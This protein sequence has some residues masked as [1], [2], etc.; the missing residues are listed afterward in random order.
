VVHRNRHGP[1]PWLIFGGWI[2][3]IGAFVGCASEIRTSHDQ[4]TTVDISRYAIYA[5]ISKDSLIPPRRGEGD[6]SY[7]SPIDDQ[8]IRRAVDAQM[9]AKGYRLATGDQEAELIVSYG[10]GREDKVDVYES[11]PYGGIGYPGPYGYGYGGWYGGSTTRVYRYTEGTLT[12]ELFDRKTQQA[13]WIGWGSKR[14]TDSDERDQVIQTAVAKILEPLPA[15]GD[16]T[17]APSAK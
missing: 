6:V 4:D 7:V 3:G 2:V 15:H 12:I 14:I 11:G 10:I 8:R 5:W 13:L 9:S 17:A 16:G 1:S